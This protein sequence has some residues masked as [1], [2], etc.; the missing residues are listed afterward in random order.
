MNFWITCLTR[1]MQ[2]QNPIPDW[3]D[4][5]SFW[6]MLSP[7]C[8]SFFVGCKSWFR[9]RISRLWQSTTSAT[10]CGWSDLC[11]LLI[12]GG[13]VQRLPKGRFPAVYECNGCNAI[14]KMLQ[15]WCLHFCAGEEIIEIRERSG[16]SMMC[17]KL[18]RK[19]WCMGRSEKAYD[20]KKWYP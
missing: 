5:W 16:G 20:K 17:Q 11:A 7:G 10:A 6:R 3:M 9:R 4:H 19:E 2:P 12:K 15:I 14:S 1:I 18:T 8:A 13:R